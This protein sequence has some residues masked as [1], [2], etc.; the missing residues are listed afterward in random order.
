MNGNGSEQM[1]GEAAAA[2]AAKATT[3]LSF[4]PGLRARVTKSPT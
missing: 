2:A 1:P 4:F 3:A